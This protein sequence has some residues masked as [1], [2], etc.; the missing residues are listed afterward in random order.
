MLET[1]FLA[2]WWKGD[3]CT[4]C[5]I[6]FLL[7]PLVGNGVHATTFCF[8]EVCFQHCVWC[9]LPFQLWSGIWQLWG[10]TGS[11]GRPWTFL[12]ENTNLGMSQLS[13]LN[14]AWVLKSTKFQEQSQANI[15]LFPS[16]SCTLHQIRMQLRS[17]VGRPDCHGTNG[18][19]QEWF[20]IPGNGSVW[21][22]DVAM[23]RSR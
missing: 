23:L 1:F 9:W 20:V 21:L 7:S 6:W 17:W 15:L 12:L 11:R 10:P 14:I 3:V 5:T 4:S 2:T 13:T 16:L 22:S 19:L 18:L 8:A